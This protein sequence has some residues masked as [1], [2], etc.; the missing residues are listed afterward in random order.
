MKSSTT[1]VH[2][3]VF[4]S[5]DFPWKWSLSDLKSV[6]KHGLRVFSCFSCG[7]G[8][9]MGYKLAG[10]EVLGNVEIDQRMMKLY[11]KNLNPQYSYLMDIR[12][13]LKRDDLPGELYDLDI[14]DGSPPCTVFSTLGNREK[15]WGKMKKF[16]EGQ[17]MQT[18]DDLFFVFIDLVKKLK[19]KVVVAENVVGLV[20]KNARYYVNKIIKSFNDIGY[21]IQIFRLN[22]A[23][24]GVPQ[25]RERIIFVCR[26][27]ETFEKINLNFRCKPIT[28]GKIRTKKG[29]Q[30]IDKGCKFSRLLQHRRKGDLTLSSIQ[31]RELK[32]KGLYTCSI[33]SDNLVAKTITTSSPYFRMCDGLWLSDGDIINCSTFPQDYDFMGQNVQ[34]VCGMCVPPVMM[35]QIARQIYLQWFGGDEVEAEAE[36][37]IP[38]GAIVNSGEFYPI[39]EH[40]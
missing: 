8:S 17:Q 1:S 7:G 12:D 31:H 10:Y 24:M 6:P 33:L 16:A 5:T 29:K 9:S 18:L 36:D 20:L 38:P 2:G 32:R 27:K 3:A 19:P 39:G 4:A 25:T 11:R 28:F 40:P 37:D 13:F 22:A 34:Y 26:K 35:A 15:D 30:F 23:F 14:L 21:D